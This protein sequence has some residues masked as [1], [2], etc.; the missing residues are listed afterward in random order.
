MGAEFYDVLVCRHS[1]RGECS[2]YKCRKYECPHH[3]CYIPQGYVEY[4]EWN[5]FSKSADV[6][7]PSFRTKA[8]MIIQNNR[9]QHG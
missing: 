5:P 1:K 8:Q 4:Y 7:C 3:A 6:K 2:K 9:R